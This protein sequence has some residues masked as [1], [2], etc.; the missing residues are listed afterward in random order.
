MVD[1]YIYTFYDETK[2]WIMD[3]NKILFN[4]EVNERRISENFYDLFDNAGV[5]FNEIKRFAFINGP[6]S[7][8]SLRFFLTFAKG[9]KVSVPDIEIIPLNLLELM[10]FTQNG[11]VN[12]I[13]GGS[14]EFLKFF[15]Y[16]KYRK[17]DNDFKIIEDVKLISYEDAKKIENPLFIGVKPDFDI[18]EYNI[19][20]IDMI[21]F[22]DYKSEKG[23]IENII[24]LTPYYYKQFVTKKV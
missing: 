5:K 9:L 24:S 17:T 18:N 20:L 7:F 22:S 13:M 3:N 12:V 23:D 16:G 10:A 4:L 11:E 15:H 6:G 1:L 21:N 8:T 2:Y 14:R 19:D